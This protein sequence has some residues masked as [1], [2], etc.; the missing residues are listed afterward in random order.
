MSLENN[1]N[2]EPIVLDNMYLIRFKML[3]AFYEDYFYRTYNNDDM[4]ILA[5]LQ[6]EL[7][8]SSLFLQRNLD[9]MIGS[10]YI[11]DDKKITSISFK[12]IKFVEEVTDG[13]L[14]YN[15]QSIKQNEGHISNK[16]QTN[17]LLVD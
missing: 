5:Y 14:H 11:G 3:Y 2:E 1:N 10:G 12:G 15:D 7:D 13:Q 9:Y 16:F 6:N 4:E 8:L 17:D